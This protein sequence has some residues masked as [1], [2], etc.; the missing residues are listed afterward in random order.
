[1]M[2]TVKQDLLKSVLMAPVNLF[3]DLMPTSKIQGKLQ[4]DIWCIEGLFWFCT[5]MISELISINTTIMLIAQQDPTALLYLVIAAV[6]GYFIQIDENKSR[7]E[8]IR[9]YCLFEG[10]VDQAESELF[11]GAKNIRALG[12]QDYALGVLSEAKD[13]NKLA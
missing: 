2:A 7:T 10:E 1:M 9:G 3:F 13:Y 5:W 6:Y 8:L 12:T 4:G 11:D